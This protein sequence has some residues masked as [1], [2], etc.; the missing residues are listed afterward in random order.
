MTIDV[1]SYTDAQFA[2]LSDAQVLEVQE[3]QLKKNRLYIQLEENKRKENYYS[4]MVPLNIA[5]LTSDC[6]ERRM[7][8]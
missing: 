8:S 2:A 7:A 4:G 3:A 6:L 5:E 1:I